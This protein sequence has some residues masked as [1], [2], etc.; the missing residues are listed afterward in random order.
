[1]SIFPA[2]SD[3]LLTNPE[4]EAMYQFSLTKT[5]ARTDR[6]KLFSGKTFYVTPGVK[7]SYK[8]IHNIV[9]AAGGR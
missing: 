6:N 5:L 2:E 7:P 3:Y 9:E 4:V 8:I 1:M